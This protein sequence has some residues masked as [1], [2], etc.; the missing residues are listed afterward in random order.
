MKSLTQ[1]LLRRLSARKAAKLAPTERTVSYLCD[2]LQEQF[3]FKARI[4]DTW[5]E[6]SA[7]GERILGWLGAAQATFLAPAKQACGLAIL[8]AIVSHGVVALAARGTDSE[9]TLHAA[10]EFVMVNATEAECLLATSILLVANSLCISQ[11]C[12]VVTAAGTSDF[13]FKA[14]IGDRWGEASAAGERILGRLGAAQAAFL[15]PAEQ[16][17][18]LAILEAIISHGVVALAARGTDG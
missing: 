12:L 6:A 1:V 5:G 2:L 15:A 7:A 10:G 13:A 18:G 9:V 17:C 11:S 14:R 16:A 3:A 8:E 4:G